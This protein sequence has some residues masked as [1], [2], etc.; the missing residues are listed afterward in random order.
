MKKKTKRKILIFIKTFLYL[1]IISNIL[2][3]TYLVLN[4]HDY[5]LYFLISSVII[6][7][8]PAVFLSR[9]SNKHYKKIEKIKLDTFGMLIAMPIIS[10]L[11]LAS[12]FT[13][14]KLKENKIFK[15][16]EI[17]FENYEKYYDFE[18]GESYRLDVD[19]KKLYY[20]DEY[21]LKSIKPIYYYDLPNKEIKAYELNGKYLIENNGL[22]YI[23]N[24]LDITSE[25]Y[26][27]NASVVKNYET[28]YI[29]KGNN[30]KTVNE[31]YKSE[32]SEKF[33]YLYKKYNNILFT[34][35]KIYDLRIQVLNSFES[36]QLA[37]YNKKNIEIPIQDK[38]YILEYTFNNKLEIIYT[39][40][41]K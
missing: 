14:T 29:L 38:I 15:T 36:S 22:T 2:F 24:N 26:K 40:K 23:T 16:N 5:S 12:A 35:E 39:K 9:L 6:S 41:E 27:I 31:E 7:I 13:F 3:L 19:T 34:Q 37:M 20:M 1:I 8:I 11:L 21:N 10:I 4:H 32:Q 25:L 33:L 18:N 30:F 17:I 28:Y